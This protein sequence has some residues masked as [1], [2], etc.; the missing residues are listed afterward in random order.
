MKNE[1]KETKRALDELEKRLGKK[2]LYNELLRRT[3]QIRAEVL[4][5]NH[6]TANYTVAM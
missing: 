3:I 6:K 4:T 5:T 1:E 2:L